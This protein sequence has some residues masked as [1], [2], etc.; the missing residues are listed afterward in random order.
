MLPTLYSEYS[1][2]PLCQVVLVIVGAMHS[3][4]KPI[5]F[6]GET[7]AMQRKTKPKKIEK[8]NRKGKRIRAKSG[9]WRE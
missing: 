4:Q 1:C 6:A 3:A 9:M 5:Q 2:S 8:V 7:N